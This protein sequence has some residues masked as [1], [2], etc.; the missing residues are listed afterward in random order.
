MSLGLINFCL[1]LIS[2]QQQLG[3]NTEALLALASVSHSVKKL[4]TE[5]VHAANRF[6]NEAWEL[7]LVLPSTA[8][9]NSESGM[10]CTAPLTPSVP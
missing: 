2:K 1:A 5:A 10:I 7:S 8:T 6:I 4:P 3:P 9:L